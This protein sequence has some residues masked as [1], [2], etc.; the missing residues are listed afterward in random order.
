LRVSKSLHLV[1]LL[2]TTWMSLGYPSRGGVNARS[3]RTT[4]PGLRDRVS[5]REGPRLPARRSANRRRRGDRRP[6]GCIRCQSGSTRKRIGLAA[7]LPLCLGTAPAQATN[8]GPDAHHQHCEDAGHGCQQRRDDQAE[9]PS[10][11]NRRDQPPE[12]K[13]AL[14]AR[15]HERADQ[16]PDRTPLHQPQRDSNCSSQRR[17]DQLGD[18][19]QRPRELSAKP[20]ERGQEPAPC[21]MT[22]SLSATITAPGWFRRACAPPRGV[23]GPIG[24][25]LCCVHLPCRPDLLPGF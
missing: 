11:G 9:S 12:A 25:C 13:A 18:P 2:H 20:P 3:S 6:L 23:C 8:S 4:R 19:P 21:P 22:R 7:L 16:S 5:R 24:L 17:A 14:L 15:A 1:P 10:D